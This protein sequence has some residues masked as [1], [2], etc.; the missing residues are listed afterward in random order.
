M[1]RIKIEVI[2]AQVDTRSGVSKASGKPWEMSTQ[3]AYLHKANEPYPE[4][5]QISLDDKEK[6][7]Q[8]GV[9]S[10]DPAELVKVGSFGSI[11]FDDRKLDSKL[12]LE[13]P[14]KV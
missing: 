5:I 12:K 2:S 13:G 9:Y 8:P 11:E 3:D 14:L 1:S 4:K 7:K 10:V 6:P